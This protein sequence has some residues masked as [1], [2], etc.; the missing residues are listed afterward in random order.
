MTTKQ[1][2]TE[3]KVL[4]SFISEFTFSPDF[5]QINGDYAY[6]HINSTIYYCRL[7]SRGVKKNSWRLEVYN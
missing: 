5:I 1:I 6:A 7:N 3:Q 2:A 4:N